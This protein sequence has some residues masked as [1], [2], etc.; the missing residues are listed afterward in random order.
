M[1]TEAAIPLTS[2]LIKLVVGLLMREGKPYLG[3]AIMSSWAALLRAS[4]TLPLC[5]ADVALRGDSRIADAGDDCVGI[6]VS[7]GKTGKGQ[8]AM[9]YDVQCCSFIEDIVSRAKFSKRAK[10]FKLTY[11]DLLDDVKHAG[12][13]LWLGVQLTTHSCRVGGALTLYLKGVSVETIAQRGRWESV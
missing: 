5:V 9:V 11:H 4:E 1:P 2:E 8:F 12:N 7:D 3:G 10:L 13:Q 6:H